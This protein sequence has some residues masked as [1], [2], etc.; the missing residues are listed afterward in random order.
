M[1]KISI[2]LCFLVFSLIISCTKDKTDPP[3]NSCSAGT[4]YD[5]EVKEIIDASCAYSGCHDGQTSGVPWNFTSYGG[6]VSVLNNGSF[7]SRVFDFKDNPEIGMPLDR[8]VDLGGPAN[9][10]PEQ[11][12]ILQMWV[13]AGFPET[14]VNVSAT[15]DE[16]VQAIIDGSCAYT[17]CHNGSPGVPGDYSNFDGLTQDIVEGN[18][19]RRV[20]EIRD[21]P[22]QGMP[23]NRGD[24]PQDLTEEEF[25]LILCWIEN[26]YPEN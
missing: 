15:Y 25:Q 1:Q 8:A 26:G 2:I 12:D 11:L 21:D 19:F 24:G 9:L 18:F 23:P 10:T 13:D 7:S 20:V 6:M 16:S 17:P 3:D 22:N 4:D 5:S 14:A